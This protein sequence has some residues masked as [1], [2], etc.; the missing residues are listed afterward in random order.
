MKKKGWYWYDGHET[1][2]H[3]FIPVHVLEDETDK[4]RTKVY[5]PGFGNDH[6]EKLNGQFGA[7]IPDYDPD[8]ISCHTCGSVH[9]DEES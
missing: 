5:I 9:W 8:R 4:P 3:G 1:Y 2:P 6:I 7:R